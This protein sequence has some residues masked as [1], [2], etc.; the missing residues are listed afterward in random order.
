[1]HTNAVTCQI[2]IETTLANKRDT[3]T[4]KNRSWI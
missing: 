1:M 4:D 3:A 2:A